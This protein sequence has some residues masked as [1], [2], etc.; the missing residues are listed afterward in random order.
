MI[1]TKRDEKKVEILKFVSVNSVTVGEQNFANPR[2][3]FT[4]NK[5]MDIKTFLDQ[6]RFYL[7]LISLREKIV[8]KYN[9][10]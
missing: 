9:G 5:F 2:R 6:V 4:T 3:K 1:C 7:L 10:L 8:I